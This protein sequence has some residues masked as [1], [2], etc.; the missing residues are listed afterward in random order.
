[1]HEIFSASRSTSNGKRKI[2]SFISRLTIKQKPRKKFE[3]IFMFEH[4]RVIRARLE[5][6][7]MFEHTWVI[8]ARQIFCGEPVEIK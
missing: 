5:H 2:N 6:I 7:F 3:H 1:M 4:T 8:G